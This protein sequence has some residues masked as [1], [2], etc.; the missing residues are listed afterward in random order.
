MTQ[1]INGSR[2]AIGTTGKISAMLAGGAALGA[3]GHAGAQVVTQSIDTVI[4]TATSTTSV[5]V[6]QPVIG[7]GLDNDPIFTF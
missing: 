3:A 5:T 1:L 4:N 2:R 7:N 6:D